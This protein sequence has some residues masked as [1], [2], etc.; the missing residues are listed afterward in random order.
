MQGSTV[1]PLWTRGRIAGALALLA[2]WFAAVVVI[3]TERLLAGDGGTFLP[4]VAVTVV[5]P[6]AVFFAAYAASGA[7]RS[8]VLA[9]D[10]RD[11]TLLQMWRVIGFCFLPLYAYGVLPGLFAFPAGIGD[12]AVGIGAFVAV[13]RMNADPAYAVSGGVVAV[14]LAGLLD[15]AVAVTSSGFSSGFYPEL[16][17]DGVTSAPMGVWPLIVFPAFLVPLNIIVELTAL[18]K[19]AHLRRNRRVPAPRGAEAV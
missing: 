13:R 12:V 3:G 8:F 14:H 19:I 16:V 5:V 6:V 10:V 4:P 9:H 1:A 11:L 17:A 7:F 15:F 2:V 18:L